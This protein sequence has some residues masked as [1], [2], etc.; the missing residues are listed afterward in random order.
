MSTSAWLSIAALFHPLLQI[1]PL[2]LLVTC[3]TGLHKSQHVKKTK[4]SLLHTAHNN[5]R[6]HAAWQTRR[7]ENKCQSQKKDRRI[8]LWSKR[9][10]R[11]VQGHAHSRS[12]IFYFSR[13]TPLSGRFLHP[14]CYVIGSKSVLRFL[15]KTRNTHLIVSSTNL[16]LLWRNSMQITSTFLC[17]LLAFMF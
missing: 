11:I 10:C 12:N 7:T 8:Q 17:K 16:K 6:W 4:L 2:L 5:T 14:F 15:N 1:G 13:I 3:F 9:Y